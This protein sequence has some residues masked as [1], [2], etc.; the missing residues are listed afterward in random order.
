MSG[1]R[2]A[3]PQVERDEGDG[4]TQ[5]ETNRMSGESSKQWVGRMA[6]RGPGGPGSS[7]PPGMREP[8]SEGADEYATQLQLKEQQLVDA[9]DHR[10]ALL[11][12]IASG[13]ELRRCESMLEALGTPDSFAPR[14][15]WLERRVHRAGRKPSVFGGFHRGK[16]SEELELVELIRRR[17]AAAAMRDRAEQLRRDP[18]AVAAAFEREISQLEHRLRQLRERRR[19]V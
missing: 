12:G 19:G 10:R 2:P 13:E 17:D 4:S 3:E 16:A 8:P 7:L 11:R 1:G 5:R 18:A 6:G 9:I 14:I 15:A